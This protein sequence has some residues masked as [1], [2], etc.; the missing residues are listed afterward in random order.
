MSSRKRY[1]FP[2]VH[3][4]ILPVQF[5]WR[6]RK[7]PIIAALVDSGGDSIVVPKAIAEYLGS[8]MEMTDF[9]KTAGGTTTLLK[10][11]LDMF[12]GKKDQQVVYKAVDVFVVDSNDVPVLIGRNPL[13]DD[14]EITFKKKKGCLIL[15]EA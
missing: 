12:I 11:K 5:C 3:Y 14:Y 1:V 10:T 4:P 8:K 6:K 7:T 15:T 13:F 9:A 2:Y